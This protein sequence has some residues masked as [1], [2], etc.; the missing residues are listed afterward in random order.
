[1]APTKSGSL[2]E[3]AKQEK[4][5]SD[6]KNLVPKK[7]RLSADALDTNETPSKIAHLSVWGYYSSMQTRQRKCPISITFPRLEISSLLLRQYTGDQKPPSWICKPFFGRL[8]RQTHVL[9]IQLQRDN[10]NDQ[11]NETTDHRHHIWKVPNHP[12]T[13]RS[14]KYSESEA[15][16]STQDFQYQLASKTLSPGNVARDWRPS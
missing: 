5:K 13:Y 10:R 16:S 1:M 12:C 15:N 6:G 2:S 14:N 8:A 11:K 7:I 3:H 4:A 9:A